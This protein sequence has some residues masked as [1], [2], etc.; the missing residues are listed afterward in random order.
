MQSGNEERASFDGLVIF[1]DGFC[2]VFG[3]AGGGFLDAGMVGYG[4][5]FGND[6]D[7]I[8]NVEIF[9]VVV[10]GFAF[11]GD[12]TVFSDSGVFVDDGVDDFRFFADADRR[13]I[14]SRRLVC[15]AVASHHHNAV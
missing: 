10:F 8:A 14:F 4:S 15:V 2:A 6:Y 12:E 7:S 9:S 11:G 5:V 1:S 13:P 3:N